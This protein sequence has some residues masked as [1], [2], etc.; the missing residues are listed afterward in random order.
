MKKIK[1]MNQPNKTPTLDKIKEKMQLLKLYPKDE[2]LN[3][4]STTTV[5]GLQTIK[6][7]TKTTNTLR[8]SKKFQ[9]AIGTTT[10][11]TFYNTILLR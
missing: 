2:Q 3:L 9:Y 1:I 5:N 7:S 4:Q 8:P 11:Y 10:K 6:K